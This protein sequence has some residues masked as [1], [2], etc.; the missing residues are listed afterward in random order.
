VLPERQIR[1]KIEDFAPPV[2]DRSQGSQTFGDTGNKRQE[3]SFSLVFHQ[4]V[5]AISSIHAGQVS[6][7]S[8]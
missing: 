5:P 7:L 2:L 3:S 4:G 1:V 6:N 8:R